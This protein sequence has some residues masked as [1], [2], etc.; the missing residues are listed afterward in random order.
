VVE[1]QDSKVV[2]GDLALAGSFP[3]RD[4]ATSFAPAT[5][6]TACHF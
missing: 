4:D 2:P 6:H 5:R 1:F 3:T